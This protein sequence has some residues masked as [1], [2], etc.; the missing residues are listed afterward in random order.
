MTDEQ[1]KLRATIDEL[2]SELASMDH[3]DD[4]VQ[5]MLRGTLDE[6][7]TVLKQQESEDS[8]TII[9]RLNQAARH[10]EESHPTLS[11]IIG[12]II[13]TLGRMGI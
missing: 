4:D 12:S 2:H 8:S 7:H 10:Y 3:M 6:I 5:Q 1:E 11:G 13:D 9:G